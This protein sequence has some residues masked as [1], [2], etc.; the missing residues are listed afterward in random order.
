MSKC[1]SSPAELYFC[2]LVASQ[3]PCWH[4]STGAERAAGVDPWEPCLGWPPCSFA[5]RTC[6]L[7]LCKVLISQP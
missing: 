1:L 3:M 5:F 6:Y 4:G 2:V 7:L